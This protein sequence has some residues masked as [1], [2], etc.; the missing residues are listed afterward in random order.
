LLWLA[1]D[2]FFCKNNNFFKKK[3]HKNAQNYHFIMTMIQFLHHFSSFCSSSKIFPPIFFLGVKKTLYTAPNFLKN[4]VLFFSKTLKCKKNR[5]LHRV[6]T[7]V[8]FFTPSPSLHLVYCVRCSVNNTR[9][10]PHCNPCFITKN[11]HKIRV[12]KIKYHTKL[13]TK[14]ETFIKKK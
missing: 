7:D 12:V 6:Y 5:Y 13:Q 11:L 3:I 10:T 8:L 1:F 9:N 2:I 4:T 14:K